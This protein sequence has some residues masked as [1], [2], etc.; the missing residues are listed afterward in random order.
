MKKP[1]SAYLWKISFTYKQ[2]IN[3]KYS[4]FVKM[5]K[6]KS[7]INNLQMG[8]TGFRMGKRPFFCQEMQAKIFSYVGWD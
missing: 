5:K 2:P 7:A 1:R 8:R 3:Y 4:S 6:M